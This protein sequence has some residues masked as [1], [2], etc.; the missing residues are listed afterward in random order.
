[1]AAISPMQRQ[2]TQLVINITVRIQ[3]YIEHLPARS[4][5]HLGLFFARPVTAAVLS[6]LT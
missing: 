4:I 5:R 2:A 3:Y 6:E 1:M